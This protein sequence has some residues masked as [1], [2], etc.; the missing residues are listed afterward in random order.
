MNYTRM[1]AEHAAILIDNVARLRRFGLEPCDHIGIAAVGN[2][3]DILAVGLVSHSQPKLGSDAPG[4]AFGQPA[5]G[6]AQ[7]VDLRLR[8]GEQEIALVARHIGGCQEIAMARAVA[9]CSA[10]DI[11]TGRERRGAKL[12]GTGDKI[13]ELDGLVAADTRH[14]SC[15]AEIARDEI[16]DYRGA[17]TRLEIEHIMGNAE[18]CRD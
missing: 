4:F 9:P 13:G 15:A 5:K 11:M 1:A 6:K 16:V 18:L 2:K 17:E 12:L 8:R 3:A 7:I 10:V 14:R